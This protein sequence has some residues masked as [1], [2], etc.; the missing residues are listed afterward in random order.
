LKPAHTNRSHRVPTE[1]RLLHSLPST[2]A[3]GEAAV[4]GLSNRGFVSMW[5]HD[6]ERVSGFAAGQILGKHYSLLFLPEDRHSGTPDR[7][8]HDAATDGRVTTE[9][10]RVRPDGSRYWASDDIHSLR[11]DAGRLRGFRNTLRDESG[12]V[13]TQSEIAEMARNEEL[14]RIASL[15][16]GPIQRLFSVGAVLREAA[17]I[18]GGDR[19]PG[20]H[21]AGA[22][23]ELDDAIAELRRAALAPSRSLAQESRAP[24]VVPAADLERSHRYAQQLQRALDSRIVIEQ[25]KGML[26]SHNDISVDEAFD[27]L[28]QHA[29]R[30]N[31][32]IHRV[33][34][35]V[36]RLGLRL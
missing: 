25:A 22:V 1:A 33:A 15:M 18:R 29:R 3:T 2:G 19:E 30:N 10:W 14:E 35:A 8:L 13:R 20:R 36:V 31:S 24:S 16:H 11:D 6:A 34:H 5:D 17:E 7:L 4:F 28:R 26:A 32:D 21:I 23:I 12:R 9:G 27:L